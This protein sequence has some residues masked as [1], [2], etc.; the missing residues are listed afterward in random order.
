MT[1]LK[2]LAEYHVSL[3]G[4]T[5]HAEHSA[6]LESLPTFSSEM[7][8]AAASPAAVLELFG[9]WEKEKTVSLGWYK[10]WD[11]V[12]SQRDRLK[13]ECEALRLDAERFRYME[14]DADSGL[15]RIYGDDWLSVVD[16]GV[17]TSK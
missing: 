7:F 4:E 13:A 3:H 17:M 9:E 2:K 10:N 16:L 1:D 8:V 6:A 5:W 15:R 11:S 14:Q 12:V